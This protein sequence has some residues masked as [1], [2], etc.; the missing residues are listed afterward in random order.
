M[1]SFITA[2]WRGRPLTDYRTVV[3]LI[4]GTTTQTGLIVKARLDR[5]KYRRGIKVPKKELQA[6]HLTPHDF[7]GE[8]NYT[9]A[10]KPRSV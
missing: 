9:I 2:N 1:F 6:L 10:P 3:N 7:H 5:R 8:W 4:A